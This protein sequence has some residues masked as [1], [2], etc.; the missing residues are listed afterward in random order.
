MTLEFFQYTQGWLWY[1]QIFQQEVGLNHVHFW[2]S[3]NIRAILKYTGKIPMSLSSPLLKF[4][5]GVRPNWTRFPKNHVNW[6]PLLKLF[7]WHCHLTMEFSLNYSHWSHEFRDKNV[8][9][10]GIPLIWQ[11]NTLNISKTKDFVRFAEITAILLYLGKIP[12]HP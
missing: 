10:I 12:I 6:F 4:L 9:S 7:Q 5:Q 2:K 1:S 8:D 11:A 3:V